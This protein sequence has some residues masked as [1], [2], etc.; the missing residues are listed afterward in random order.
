MAGMT[1]GRPRV[2]FGMSAIVMAALI[3]PANLYEAQLRKRLAHN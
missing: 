1:V 2:R 3:E